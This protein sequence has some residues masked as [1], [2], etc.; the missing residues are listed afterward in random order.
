MSC[1]FNRYSFLTIVSDDVHVSRAKRT[2]LLASFG[3]QLGLFFD[4][5]EA[6]DMLLRN[7]G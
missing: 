6:G 2:L 5:E 7:V 3:F 4:P 1:N